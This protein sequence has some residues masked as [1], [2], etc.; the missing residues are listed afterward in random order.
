MHPVMV[1]KEY[2]GLDLPKISSEIP[3][4]WEKH[5]IFEKSTY[6]RANRPPY[7][8]Y[9]GLPSA[10]GMPGIHH[11][12]AR[13]IKDIFVAT[14]PK[15]LSSKT[16]SRVGYPWP[17]VELGVEKA[18]GITKDAIGKSISIEQYNRACK[19]AVMKYTDVWNQLTQKMGYWADMDDPYVTYTSK[20]RKPSGG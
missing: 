19:E 13:T 4:F 15:R 14:N 5:R 10:N 3:N 16:K 17:P 11:V 18:L 8:F 6:E 12:M 2:K 1:F 7:I 20:Y 9:E